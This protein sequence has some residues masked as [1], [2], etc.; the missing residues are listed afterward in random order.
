MNGRIYV[1]VD[2]ASLEHQIEAQAESGEVLWRARVPNTQEG[3]QTVVERVRVWQEE[4]HEVWVGL[5]GLG[6]YA[7]PLDRLLFAAGAFVVGVHPTQAARFRELLR[8]QPDKDD[9]LDAGLLAEWLRWQARNGE[10]EPSVV[11]DE[12]FEAVRE[13]ARAFQEATTLKVRLQNQLVHKVRIYWPDL[14]VGKEFFE[15]TDAAGLLA[16][17]SQYPTPEAVVKAGVKR[18]EKVLREASRRDSREL[19]GQLME[20]ARRLAGAV[21]MAPATALVVKQLACDVADA[22]S[23]VRKWEGILTQLLEQ[24]PFGRFLL[25]LPGVGP[26]TGGCFLGE[27]GDLGRFEDDA[28]LAR[29]S[30]TAPVKVQSGKSPSR[31]YDGHRYNHHLKRAVLLMVRSMVQHDERSQA[32][33]AKQRLAGKTYWQAIKKLARYILRFLWKSWQQIVQSKANNLDLSPAERALLP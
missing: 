12:Y 2:V 17:L 29:Y 21:P 31:H 27:A 7:S 24:H 4:G 15:R 18:I 3:C 13:A 26:R 19:A 28:K 10:L 1:G 25:D 22:A 20:Q 14:L 9:R 23:H 5:E 32:Y 8:V 16:L 33:T 6:G 30:G 11:R